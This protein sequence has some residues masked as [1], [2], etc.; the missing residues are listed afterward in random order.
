[1]HNNGELNIFLINWNVFLIYKIL[2]IRYIMKRI[3]N[4]N[5]ENHYPIKMI[6]FG[7][8]IFFN[9]MH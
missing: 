1:M 3:R 7:I 4:L 9:G 2:L 8:K 6:H 5:L